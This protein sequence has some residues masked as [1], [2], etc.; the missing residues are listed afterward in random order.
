MF[1]NKKQTTDDSQNRT[2]NPRGIKFYIKFFFSHTWE[3]GWY[4]LAIQSIW[5]IW[6][7]IW[8]YNTFIK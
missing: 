3:W 8:S 1:V 5:V 4:I 6:F 2:K 7:L